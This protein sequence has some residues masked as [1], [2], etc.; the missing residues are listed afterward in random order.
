LLGL[1]LFSSCGAAWATLAQQ[2]TL[3]DL[4]VDNLRA[5]PTHVTRMDKQ[6]GTAVGWFDASGYPQ[7]IAI[8]PKPGDIGPRFS[9]AEGVRGSQV[10]GFIGDFNSISFGN[11]DF[12]AI[13]WDNGTPRD[14]GDLG[15]ADGSSLLYSKAT[16]INPAGDIWGHGTV[17]DAR[18]DYVP[19]LWAG[20]TLLVPLPTLGGRF[21][22]VNA[23]NDRGDGAGESMTP[24]GETHCTFWPAAGGVQDCHP[25]N[26]TTESHAIDMN[27]LSQLAAIAVQNGQTFSYLWAW[28]GIFWLMPLQGDDQSFVKAIND[29][30]D[31]VGR[32]CL[33]NTCRAI[34]WENGQPTELLP[35]VTNAPGWTLTDAVGIDNNGSIIVLGTLNNEPHLARLS[36]IV[37]Q[38][39]AYVDW[40]WDI[41]N[42]YV[43]RW[44]VWRK[45]IEWYY[46]PD[47]RARR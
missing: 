44:N 10:V 24:A 36:P 42:Y 47:L 21:G 31:P 38:S 17:Q 12:H 32:S 8:Y 26:G 40:R 16:C 15:S 34:A 5:G 9:L 35:R 45:S 3:T 39:L 7:A 2:Y 41:F 30:G 27:N 22:Q 18:F 11:Y 14:L 28:P 46:R 20:Q 23:C 33:Q 1:A 13:L 19:L 37:T 43:D 4:G 6:A 29:T 25:Q